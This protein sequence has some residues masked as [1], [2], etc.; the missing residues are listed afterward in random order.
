[1]SL[2]SYYLKVTGEKQGLIKGSVTQKGREGLIE[3]KGWGW[4]VV[5]PRDAASGLPTGKRQHKP[6]TFKATLSRASA[7]LTQ[8][9]VTNE[10]LKDV[11]LSCW[12]PE[13]YTTTTGTERLYYKIALLNA[14]ISSIVTSGPEEDILPFEEI[15]MTY[16]KI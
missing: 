15:S 6:I 16:Q 12:K 5:S 8:A 3:L 1:M 9:L 2:N 13:M 4:S 10:N 11:L 14:S 7:L